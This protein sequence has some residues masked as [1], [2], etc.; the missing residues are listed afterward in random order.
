MNTVIALFNPGSNKTTTA[1][2]YQYDYGQRLQFAGIELPATYTVHFSNY[3]DNVAKKVLG[4]S[5]GVDIPDEYLETGLPVYAWVYLHT[6]ENDGETVYEVTIPVRKRSEP[7]D[8]TPTPAQQSIIDQLVETV[9][10]V[11]DRVEAVE[12]KTDAGYIIRMRNAS[13]SFSNEVTIGGVR[14]DD[15]P[16][17]WEAE[18]IGTS[19]WYK[20]TIYLYPASSGTGVD[21][22]STMRPIWNCDVYSKTKGVSIPAAVRSEGEPGNWT[23]HVVTFYYPEALTGLFEVAYLI[24][25]RG[26]LGG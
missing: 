11:E 15:V 22:L 23:H 19:E 10:D 2:R 5:T 21:H 1:F 24:L 18:Q 17:Q 8:E 16:L 26:G 6:G 4:D 20:H 12:E 14:L 25:A 7:V 13:I 3:I 9:S